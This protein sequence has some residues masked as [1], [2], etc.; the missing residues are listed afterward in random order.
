MGNDGIGHLII[1]KYLCEENYIFFLVFFR[2]RKMFTNSLDSAKKVYFL[3]K[4]TCSTIR[5]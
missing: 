3:H 1:K 4:S 2:G 5:Q